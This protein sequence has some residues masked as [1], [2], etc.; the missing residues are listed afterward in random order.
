MNLVQKFLS[1]YIVWGG[2]IVTRL[3]AYQDCMQRGIVGS[4]RDYAV[5]AR[6]AVDAPDD[7]AN[8][9]AWLR[10][11]QAEEQSR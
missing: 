6:K 10:Q 3:E 5:F 1:E 7:A 8:Q 9:L 2:P 4:E 11:V